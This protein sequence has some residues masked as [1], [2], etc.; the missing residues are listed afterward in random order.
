M[1]PTFPRHGS[2]AILAASIFLLL[3]FCTPGLHAQPAPE[4]PPSPTSSLDLPTYQSELARIQEL[5]ESAIAA[6][7]EK[8]LNDLRTSLPSNWHVAT[9][10]QEFTVSTAEISAELRAIAQNLPLSRS[11][12]A[13]LAN[14]LR[15]MQQEAAALRYAIDHPNP[16][17]ASADAKLKNILARSQFQESTGPTAMEILKARVERWLIEHILSLL[18]KL[19]IGARTGNFLGW[20][21]IFLALIVLF[22]YAYRAL[23]KNSANP[24]F[25]AEATPLPSDA[26]QWLAEA[27]TAA[28]RGDFREAIHCAYWASVARLEDL[29]LLTRD[30]ARTP[31]ESLRLLEPHPREQTL[32]RPITSSFELIWYG[33]RPASVT[34]WQGAKDHLEK[35]GCL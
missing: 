20:A 30:R 8:Q 29:R 1:P 10:T 2:A 25:A 4:T 22:Y 11:H 35:I 24:A 28:E 32:L 16:S 18:R 23:A 7:D 34:D 33:Y 3:S 17:A 27:Q 9:P 26:R 13:R 5:S 19:H 14:R 15:T 21:I 31:R 12:A 6:K